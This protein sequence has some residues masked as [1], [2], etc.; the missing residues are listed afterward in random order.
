[1]DPRELVRRGYD[2]VGD[3]YDTKCA[4]RNASLYA[5]WLAKLASMLPRGAEILD[6]GCG[7]GKFTARLLAEE[8]HVT[9]VDISPVQIDRARTLVPNADFICADMSEV[10]FPADR[11]DA[12]VALYSII[13]IPLTEQPGLFERIAEWLRPGG[14]LLAILGEQAWTG[15]EESWLGVESAT[16]YWSHESAGTYRRWLTDLGFAI[17]EEEFV[18]EEEGGHRLFLSHINK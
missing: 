12:V 18:P 17:V 5:E 4:Q 10:E 8:F 6:L 9:G 14:Y 13:H 16:M 11:F 1:M 2:L 15:T 7:T 3:T